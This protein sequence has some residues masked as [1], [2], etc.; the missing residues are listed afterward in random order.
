MPRTLGHQVSNSERN[1][2][3]KANIWCY[4]VSSFN[5]WLPIYYFIMGAAFQVV[6]FCVHYPV[7]SLP[8]NKIFE[9]LNLYS[10][11][12]WVGRESGKGWIMAKPR[13]KHSV[14][15]GLLDNPTISSSLRTHYTFVKGSVNVLLLFVNLVYIEWAWNSSTVKPRWLKVEGCLMVWHRK[16]SSQWLPHSGGAFFWL[17]TT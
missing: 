5:K 14:S 13:R 8:I 12:C 10:K 11:G 1:E 7:H 3:K 16:C 9:K 4:I 2:G 6:Y 17:Y 15:V